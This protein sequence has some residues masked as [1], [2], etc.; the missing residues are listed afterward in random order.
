MWT[1]HYPHMLLYHK[2]STNLTCTCAMNI[3]CTCTIN[4]DDC[5]N[6]VLYSVCVCVC[7]RPINLSLLPMHITT[8][9]TIQYIIITI[10]NIHR[11][12][13]SNI[14]CIH[15]YMYKLGLC[16]VCGIVACVGSGWCTWVVRVGT[17]KDL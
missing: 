15:M 2:H 12:S 10:I 13:T 1:I 14:H 16:Y 5:N 4:I 11:T 6:Y 17:I 7:V 9:H 3:A 8:T